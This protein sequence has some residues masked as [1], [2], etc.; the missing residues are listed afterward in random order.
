MKI[1]FLVGLYIC[2]SFFAK[3]TPSQVPK[4]IAYGVLLDNTGTLRAQL[5]D[6]KGVGKIIVSQLNSQGL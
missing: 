2:I 3:I 6:V 1:Y 5:D 4:N